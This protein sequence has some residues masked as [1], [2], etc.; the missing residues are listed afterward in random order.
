MWEQV[1]VLHVEGSRHRPQTH[2]RLDKAAA[3]Q[4]VFEDALI[5]IV[6]FLVRSTGSDRLVLTGGTALNAVANMRL[7]E[8]FDETYYERVLGKRGRLH[9]WAPP[10][11]NDAGVTLGAAYL[12][13]YH[14]GA[15]I[16]APLERAFYCGWAPTEAEIGAAIRSASDV[17]WVSLGD[18]SSRAERD[19]LADLMA[20]ITSQ[21][22]IIA[23]FQGAAETGPRALGHRSI[24]A[25]PC[26]PRTREFLNDRVKYREAIRPLAPML[27]L[28]AAKRWFDLSDGCVRRR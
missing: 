8:H 23:L 6:D 24:L 13:G 25:N 9:I 15:G 1:A 12:F 17:A 28:E 22:G 4:L 2:V 3:T 5:H 7:L 19:A 11:P 20:Y 18:V 10:V 16:G 21:D 14:A 27:T 26:N